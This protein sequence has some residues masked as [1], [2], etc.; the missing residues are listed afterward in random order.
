MHKIIL[1]VSSKIEAFVK[2]KHS[3]MG[4]IMKNEK[5]FTLKTHEC[6]AV[7]EDGSITRFAPKNDISNDTT[8]HLV[9]PKSAG[10][11]VQGEIVSISNDPLF[12][13]KVV[14]TIKKR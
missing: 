13:D 2:E 11:T 14:C 5:S 4:D 3:D 8:V 1:G 7:E 9:R 12:G 6:A 10:G